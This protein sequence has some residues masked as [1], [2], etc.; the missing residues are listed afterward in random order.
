M[1]EVQEEIKAATEEQNR[2]RKRKLEETEGED[3]EMTKEPEANGQQETK[4][5]DE[6]VK[7]EQQQQNGEQEKK[8]AIDQ[9]L[10]PVDMNVEPRVGPIDEEKKYKKLI[11]FRNK[12]Y[13]APLTTV[14]N[15][16]FRRICKEFGVD[17]TCGEM[18]MARNL[19]QV[20]TWKNLPLG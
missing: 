6:K 9:D 20:R 3:E 1:K 11:D 4:E 18:A 15:L 13:L 12:T 19:L 10:P 2:N 17:I 8:P 16:P 7:E 5:E 14:G